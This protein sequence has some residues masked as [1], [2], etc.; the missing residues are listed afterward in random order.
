MKRLQV[1]LLA[2]AGT[3]AIGSSAQAGIVDNTSLANPPGVYFGSGNA[4]SNFTVDQEGNIEIGLSAIKR[5][6]GPVVPVGNVYNVPTGATTVPTKTGVN[7]GFDFSVNLNALGTGTLNL[8]NIVPTLTF[9]DVAKG[10][11]GSFNPLGIP[12]NSEF[13]TS[14]KQVCPTCTPATNY[15]FQ[16]SEALSFASIAAAFNDPTFDMN[17]NDTY[18]LTLG[19][20][21]VAGAPL[22]SDTI[23]I[24]AG[25]GATA[26]PEPGTLPLLAAGLLAFA[27]LSW[28][29]R[30]TSEKNS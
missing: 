22:G 30:Q 20:S 24:K 16:N 21:N 25:A 13:G 2:A 10:T 28:R 26:V 15:A 9:T 11:T 5:F 17:L 7:W 8:L 23:V 14:G 1:L 12:D 29:R 27:A 4:N 19:V 6:I 18:I 3:F